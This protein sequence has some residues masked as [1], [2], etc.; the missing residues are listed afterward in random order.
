MTDGDRT[1]DV[2]K[3]ITQVKSRADRLRHILQAQDVELDLRLL[4]LYISGCCSILAYGSKAWPMD[5]KTCR[6]LNGANA[7][8]LSHITGRS[9]HEET[10]SSTTTF[11]LI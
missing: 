3:W 2:R 7:Y 4:R 9:G 6:I 5:A 10:S 11:N 1:P 8:M